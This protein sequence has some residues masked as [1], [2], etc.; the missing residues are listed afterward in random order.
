MSGFDYF[1]KVYANYANFNGRAR[2]KEYWYF[3]L[4]YNIF[5]LLLFFLDLIVF[6]EDGFELFSGLFSLASLI[7][8]LAVGARRLHDT[9]RSGWWQLLAFI[10]IIG[11]IVL[12]Y[13]FVLDSDNGD[14]DYGSNPKIDDL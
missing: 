12:I 3:T 5:I 2:R 7:P 4:F 8:Y 6:G 10:P 9:N 14:N 1:K 11:A 13:F